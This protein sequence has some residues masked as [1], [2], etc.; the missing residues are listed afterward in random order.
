MW[1]GAG[2][3]EDW[4]DEAVWHKVNPS[5]GVTVPIEKVWVACEQAKQSPAE[6]NTFSQLRLNQWVKQSVR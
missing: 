3:D 5:L 1:C 2:Q 4:T 6:E